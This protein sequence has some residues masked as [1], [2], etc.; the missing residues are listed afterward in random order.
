[1]TSDD[2]QTIAGYHLR[3]RLGNGGQGVVYLAEAAGGRTLALKVLHRPAD[4]QLRDRFA[5]EVAAARRVSPA[6]IARIVDVCLDG[7][8]PYIASEYIEG[9]TLAHAVAT[10]GPFAPEPLT[11]LASGLV[12]ALAAIHRAGIVH[13][14]LKPANV[15]LSSDG[16]RLIDF[17]LARAGDMTATTS[18]NVVGTPL[19]LAPESF[20]G[21]R[22]EPA[23]DVFAWA[24]V[25]YY[26]ATGRHAFAAEGI[27]A[28]MHRILHDSP[29]LAALPEPLRTPLAAALTKDP[30]HRPTAADLLLDLTGVGHRTP[31][32]APAPSPE[33]A[34]EPAPA[35]PPAPKP[36]RSRGRGKRV[37][38]ALAGVGV[39][40]AGVV[41]ILAFDSGTAGGPKAVA[42]VTGAVR[43]STHPAGQPTANPAGQPTGNPA[44]LPTEHLAGQPTEAAAGQPPD[45]P[46]GRPTED[47]AGWSQEGSVGQPTEPPPAQSSENPAG[48]PIEDPPIHPT[49]DPAGLP[50]VRPTDPDTTRPPHAQPAGPYPAEVDTGNIRT[51][52]NLSR[53]E[54]AARAAQLTAAGF[55]PISLSLVTGERYTVVW[56]KRPGP[57]L[58]MF[59]GLSQE[60]TQRLLARASAMGYRVELIAGLGAGRRVTYAGALVKQRGNHAFWGLTEVRFRAKIRHYQTR[61]TLR[62]VSA[63]GPPGDRRYAAVWSPGKTAWR[64]T[65]NLDWATQERTHR[66]LRAQGYRP[67]TL[68]ATP[69]RRYSTVWRKDSRPYLHYG[70]LT[71]AAYRDR[72]RAAKDYHPAVI[73]V[74]GTARRPVFT[75]IWAP[76]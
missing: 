73:Q 67:A 66:R 26:A 14:D 20:H 25:V 74:S 53:A 5:K 17:G 31:P 22:A 69:D 70:D 44:D 18:G 47:P 58:R 2:P 46:A 9:P 43:P 36:A 49:E 54:H 7:P 34:P 42:P 60:A 62:W 72:L 3:G 57:K 28:V 1:M 48:R 38:G 24:A 13:R 12:M 15:L 68:A 37:A 11:R 33:P 8:Q 50:S 21:H 55:R 64:T 4:P 59:H 40:V 19:Y 65:L 75:A 56:A 71:P 51:Y 30:A 10:T 41:A 39:T 32:P 29:D 23:A 16:P 27:P 6:W 63:Y 61:M 35:P 76:G 52:Y 45:D